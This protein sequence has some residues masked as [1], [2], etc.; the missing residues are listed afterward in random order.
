MGEDT[1]AAML[2]QALAVKDKEDF[3]GIFIQSVSLFVVTKHR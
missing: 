2:S 3:K 1:P